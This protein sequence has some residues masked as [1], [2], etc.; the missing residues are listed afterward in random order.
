MNKNRYGEV[1]N[2]K[3]TYKEMAKLL[4][5]GKTVGIGWTDELST[6]LDIVFKL[7]LD[8][9]EGYFQ[10]GLREN[11]LYVSIISFTS[12]GFCVENGI[13]LGGYIQ[14][15]LNMNNETGD[16]LANLI[17]GI[18]GELNEISN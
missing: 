10:R 14:E 18:I 4:K 5:D 16:E 17:N 13:K 15:K 1:I 12:F 7:G 6:H 3:D 2:G 8:T 9:K 11:Y